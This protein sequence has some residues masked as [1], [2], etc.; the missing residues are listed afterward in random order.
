[1]AGDQQKTWICD[2]CGYEHE[3]DHPP[4]ECPVCGV[5][6]EDFSLKEDAPGVQAGPAV[7]TG[8]AEGPLGDYLKD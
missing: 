6:P 2:V 1:M 3:G 7:E 4:D 5:G 8:T